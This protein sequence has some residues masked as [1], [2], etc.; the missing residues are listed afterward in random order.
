LA[1]QKDESYSEY[2]P[3]AAGGLELVD[4]IS[5]FTLVDNLNINGHGAGGTVKGSIKGGDAEVLMQQTHYRVPIVRGTD[6]V[7]MWTNWYIGTAIHEMLHLAGRGV[8]TDGALAKAAFDLGETKT[9]VKD[10]NTTDITKIYKLSD[11]WNEVLGRYCG[12]R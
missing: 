5:K 10:P 3:D 2:K 6:P 7:G 11:T 12:R 9:P 4:K 1:K 8:T